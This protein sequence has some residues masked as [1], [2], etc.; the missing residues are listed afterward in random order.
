VKPDTR[1]QILSSAAAVFVRAG[2]GGTS[3]QDIAAAAG[4][5]RA[6]LYNHFKSKDAIVTSLVE[7][8]T[9]RSRDLT[10]EIA[11]AGQRTPTVALRAMI[12]AYALSLLTRP[13]EFLFLMQTE[14]ILPK[15]L[16]QIQEAAKRHLYKTFVTVI[17]AGVESGEF[18]ATD[19][20]VAALC[21]FGMCAWTV[22]WFRPDARL[23]R[24]AVADF[25]AEFALLALRPA[26]AGVPPADAPGVLAR[27]REDLAQL[28]KLIAKQ[29]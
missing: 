15:R 26:A 27:L 1:K 23:S 9:V 10:G 20:A 7:D 22:Q 16:A 12:R 4:I 28:E 21:I 13:E 18:R 14:A 24:D 11:A 3:M 6:S 2:Y 8:V 29:M 25:I 19:A 5:S 17:K